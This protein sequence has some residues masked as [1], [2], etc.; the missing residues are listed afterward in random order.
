MEIDEPVFKSFRKIPS[1]NGRPFRMRITQKIHGTNAQIY[2]FEGENSK[3]ELMVGSRARWLTPEDDNHGV[4]KWAYQNKDLL[5]MD[6]RK[7]R[8]YGEWAGPGINKGEGLQRKKLFLFDKNHHFKKIDMAAI[9]MVP[10]LFDGEI[11]F[12]DIAECINE[13]MNKLKQDGSQIEEANGYPFPEGVVI[14]IYDPR[15]INKSIFFKKTF[16][17]EESAWEGKTKTTKIPADKLPDVSHLL[18]PLRLEK[19]LSRDEK[20]L[21]EY[22][23]SLVNIASDYVKDLEEEGQIP[24]VQKNLQEIENVTNEY[25]Q[26]I[27]DKNNEIKLFK[28]SLRKSLFKFIKSEVERWE[29][30]KWV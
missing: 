18:Q 12:E 2:I 28:T 30:A 8:H 10:V 24:L 19:L 7:G 4:C 26:E 11:K 13:H 3:V 1:L 22:P 16:S 21:K 6:L 29:K 23:A 20:Y 17:Q 25:W 27:A 9:D 15:G 14:E 5:I